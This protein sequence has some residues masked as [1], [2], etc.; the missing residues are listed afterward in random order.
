[1]IGRI[2]LRISETFN[3]YAELPHLDEP[4]PE[5]LTATPVNRSAPVPSYTNSPPPESF[6]AKVDSC[7]TAALVEGS[8]KLIASKN[9]GD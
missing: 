4:Q 9:P 7:G 6:T 3:E 2:Q 5:T 1:M 8:E